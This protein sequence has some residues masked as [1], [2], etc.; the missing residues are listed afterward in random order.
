MLDPGSSVV[1]E[2][3]DEDVE[4]VEDVVVVSQAT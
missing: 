4:D 2:E 1:L 3:D